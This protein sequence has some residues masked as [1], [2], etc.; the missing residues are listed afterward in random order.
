LGVPRAKSLLAAAFIAAALSPTGVLRAQPVGI[1]VT[2]RPISRVAVEGTKEV[3]PQLLLNQVRLKPGDPYDPSIVSQDIQNLTRLGR[4]AKVEA[5]VEPNADGTVR[6]T[7][8]VTEQQL[9]SDV[10]VVGNKAFSDQELL[11]PVLLQAGDPRD[12]FLIE[13]GKEEIRKIYREGGYFLADVSVDEETLNETGILILRVRE[14]PL[15]RVQEINF[16]G[17]DEAEFPSD[18]LATKIKTNTYIWIFR[19]GVLNKEQLDQD[20]ARL[21]D[22]YQEHGYLDVRVSR[23][24]DLSDDQQDARVVFIVDQG[25]KYTVSKIS[26][27]GN[28]LYTTDEILQAMALKVGDIYSA[29]RLRNTQDTLSDLYGKLGYIETQIQINRVFHET[30]PTVELQVNLKES[31]QYTVGSV[32]VRGNPL[33]QDKVIRRQVRGI[34]PGEVID[35]TGVE[36][37]KRKMKETGIIKDAKVTVLGTPDD[38]T[39][40]VLMEIQEANTGS[41]SFG[42]AV[43]SDSGVFGAIDLTQRNFDITDLPDSW[44]EFFTGRA[45]RGA[46]QYFSITLQP[47]QEFQRYQVTFR[48]PYLFESDFFLD[49]SA[50]FYTRRREDWDETRIGGTLGIGKRFGDV[51]SA[52]VRSRLEQVTIDNLQS[53][54]PVDAYAV[55]G[56]SLVDGLGFFIGRSTIDSRLFPTKGTR[57]NAGVEQSGLV[58]DYTFTRFTADFE[59]FFTVDEDFFGRKTVLSFKT[60]TGYIFDNGTIDVKDS[61]GGT[62]T[63]SEVPLFERFYAGGHRTFRGFDFRGVGPRGARFD[64]GLE[65]DDPVGGQWMFLLSTEYNF[66]IYEQ[67]LRGV[68][69]VDQGTV[70]QDVAFDQWRVA[71]GAGLRLQ[72]PFLSQ[73][74]FAFDLA[75]PVLKQ[76]GDQVRYFSFDIALP[77]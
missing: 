61:L 41:L 34:E 72:L 23:R 30:E 27:T 16:E 24:I 32:I 14:G 63:I 45:F 8:V 57:L 38:D 22:Y 39:R 48:E 66:P 60:Q 15:V 37:S 4:F 77:F 58:G 54:A 35:R 21:R 74:P 73:A 2:N 36:V 12:P 3:T 75:Y 51:W 25:R 9:L 19:K 52:T 68:F 47:G 67:F 7:Y 62:H 49:A 70:Q 17:N 65:G 1:D 5:R 6:L 55:Q 50:F 56:D 33:M 31:K 76:P 18:L 42:A 53:G 26:I 46:G 44:G 11:A 43:S 29:D 40:D 71:V 64:S 28:Q 59:V 13:R 20:V 10:Q 69:F